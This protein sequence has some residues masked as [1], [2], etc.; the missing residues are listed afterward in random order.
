MMQLEKPITVAI[1]A[2]VSDKTLPDQ[3]PKSLRLQKQA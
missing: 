3:A 1:L 2:Q